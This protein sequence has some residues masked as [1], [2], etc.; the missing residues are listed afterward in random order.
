MFCTVLLLLLLLLVLLLVHTPH[1]IHAL[2]MD[3]SCL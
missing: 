2:L 1:C 3:G